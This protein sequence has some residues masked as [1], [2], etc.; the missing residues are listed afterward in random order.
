MKRLNLTIVIVYLSLGLLFFG[1]EK[2][3][4]TDVSTVHWDRDMCARCVMVV[5][6]RHNTAQVK[7]PDTGKTYMFDDIGCAI[8]WFNDEHIK[9]KDRAVI[10]ITDL[11]TGKWIDARK[12][13]YDT[14]NITPMAYGF[15]AHKTKDTIKPDQE[16]IDYNEVVKRVIKIGK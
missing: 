16:I 5:S 4:K 10:W 15:S 14:E 11:Q 12:A 6:D 9:W 2:Q 7:N 8:L 1:C 13:F 3:S